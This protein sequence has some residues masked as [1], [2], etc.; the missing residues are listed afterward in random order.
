[1]DY[2]LAILIRINIKLLTLALCEAHIYTYI[3]SKKHNDAMHQCIEYKVEVRGW[4]LEV[5]EGGN[6]AEGKIS[7]LN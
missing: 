2:I 6:F 4:R 7:T 3:A 5:R 1:M